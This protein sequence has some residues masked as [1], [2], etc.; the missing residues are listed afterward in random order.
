MEM[1]TVTAETDDN[2]RLEYLVR[3]VMGALVIRS[4]PDS[5]KAAGVLNGSMRA[6]ARMYECWRSDCL[7]GIRNGLWAGFQK[8]TSERRPFH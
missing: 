8:E 7:D 6:N 1:T 4:A 3:E 5:H 2:D